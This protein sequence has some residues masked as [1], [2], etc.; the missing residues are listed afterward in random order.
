MRKEVKD[1]VKNVMKYLTLSILRR[2]L[3][4]LMVNILLEFEE[5][6]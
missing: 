3:A 6:H 4:L 2:R 5:T 1:A